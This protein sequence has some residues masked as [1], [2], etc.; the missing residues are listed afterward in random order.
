MQTVADVLACLG[1]MACSYTDIE[2]GKIPNKVIII[3]AVLSVYFFGTRFLL[4]FFTAVIFA[5]V[6]YCLKSGVKPLSGGDLKLMSLMTG[7]YGMTAMYMLLVSFVIAGA[8]GLILISIGRKNIKE[9]M[10]LAPYMTL[11]FLLFKIAE[12]MGINFS[13]GSLG[14]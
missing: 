12:C 10:Q 8:S 4:R 6:L 9:G 11:G 2:S 1:L 7:W 3:L 14:L 13:G 5:A